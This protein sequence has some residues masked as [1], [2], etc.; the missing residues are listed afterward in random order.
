MLA[1]LLAA[2]LAPTTKVAPVRWS[3]APIVSDI[4]ARG[5]SL[6][7]ALAPAASLT[8]APSAPS[9]A[10]DKTLAAPQAAAWK[11]P[12][13]EAVP[14]HDAI[15]QA[16]ETNWTDE[17]PVIAAAAS[18]LKDNGIE[19]DEVAVNSAAGL[20]DGLRI[21]PDMEGPRLN[22][23]AYHMQNKLG[24]TLDYV[25]KRT[26]KAG[27]T[28]AHNEH[29]NR[30]LLPRFDSPEFY[31][32]VLHEMR[33]AWFSSLKKK[34]DLRLYHLQ[35]V[36]LNGGSI[37][38]GAMYY[39]HYMSWEE[40]S[41]YPKTLR[42]LTS[43]RLRGPALDRYWQLL[44]I[45]R[46]AATLSE[47]ILKYRPTVRKTADGM[48]ADV[49]RVTFFIPEGKDPKRELE[50]RAKLTLKLVD[51][52]VPWLTKYREAVGREDWEAASAA[53]GKLVA[54]AAEAD[55]AW[56]A[57]YQ[58]PKTAPAAPVAQPAKKSFWQRLFS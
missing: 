19:S 48:R 29:E 24:T 3:P 44:D 41:N 1:L 22:K 13:A 20:F 57:D 30:I 37:V 31:P 5:L 14:L 58:K 32:A 27:G 39:T 34:G 33:H 40:L 23:M 51:E 21:R 9:A 46:S 36:A 43:A 49:G 47:Q 38:P 12:V 55:K 35:A 26:A 52:S 11:A 6:T 18:V 2:T 25:P 15:E 16:N 50:L 54:L 10:L 53:A 8:L 28:A 17:K 45:F 7:P 56:V 42:H 4:S